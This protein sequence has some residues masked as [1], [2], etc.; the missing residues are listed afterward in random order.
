MFGCDL[1]VVWP[2]LAPRWPPIG[3]SLGLALPSVHRP[4]LERFTFVFRFFISGSSSIEKSSCS[5][6][7]RSL[8]TL[9][10]LTARSS[11]PG[12]AEL[13]DEFDATRTMPGWGVA[14]EDD[15]ATRW[16]K[17]VRWSCCVMM[18]ILAWRG[19]LANGDMSAGD[20]FDP[21][22]IDGFAFGW[23][24]EFRKGDPT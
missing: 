12:G 11:L 22:R 7:I 14:S 19:G 6:S 1:H 18:L 3:P 9:V 5:S 16:F 2:P 17:R 24:D 21:G 4:P 8:P 10:A 15:S 23:S 13:E 20:G